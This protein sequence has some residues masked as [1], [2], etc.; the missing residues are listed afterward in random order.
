MSLLY[1]SPSNG[2]ELTR[3]PLS[4]VAAVIVSPR[5][6]LP[7]LL[8]HRHDG[9]AELAGKIKVALIVRGNGHDRARAVAHQDIIGDP[10]RDRLPVDGVGRIRARKDA[11]LFA[12]FRLPV[13]LRLAPRPRRIGRDGVLLLRRR[14]RCDQ[15]MLRGQH[16]KRRPPERVRARGEDGDGGEPPR[17]IWGG[18]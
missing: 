2:P 3:T 4:V 8:I 18:S 15:R 1:A 16:H 6:F 12:P 13:H 10:D 7:R 11:R 5:D 14:Q 9:Q 17:P